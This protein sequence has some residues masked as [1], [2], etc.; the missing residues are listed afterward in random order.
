M[1]YFP[2]LS[3][4][5]FMYVFFYFSIFLFF[6]F[7]YLSTYIFSAL[8]I[9]S[10]F[11]FI[12]FCFILFYFILFYLFHLI[13]FYSISFC[14]ISPYFI[15]LPFRCISRHSIRVIPIMIPLRSA[16][17]SIHLSFSFFNILSHLNSCLFIYSCI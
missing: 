9:Y 2:N 5:P 15:F 11:L 1:R 10:H 16:G 17:C 4:C 14:F 3:T 7:F 6:I 13:S 12:S 8:F